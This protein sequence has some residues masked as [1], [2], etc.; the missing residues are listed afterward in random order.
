MSFR[1]TYLFEGMSEEFIDK[2]SDA[3]VK[4]T[5]E[6]GSLVFRQGD[7]AEF[8]YFLQQGR[9]RLTVGAQGSVAKILRHCGDAFGLSSLLGSATYTT[10][11]TCLDSAKVWK[12]RGRKMNV[13]LEEDPSTGLIFFRRLAGSIRERLIDS[14]RLLLT[15]DAERKPYSYG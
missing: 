6:R 9:I 14:Y 10:S 2:V 12:I 8:L 15:Y 4:V 13:L 5:Y 11:A 7:P 1:R 3:L